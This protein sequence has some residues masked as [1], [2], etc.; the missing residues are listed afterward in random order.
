VDP[1]QPVDVVVTAELD[2]LTKV[3]TGDGSFGATPRTK[4]RN[5]ED[6]TLRRW[7]NAGTCGEEDRHGRCRGGATVRRVVLS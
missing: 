1:G 5:A 4:R 6:R 7:D 2:A 3:R